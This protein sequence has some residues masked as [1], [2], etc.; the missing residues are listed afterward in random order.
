MSGSTFLL[1][2]MVEMGIEKRKKENEVCV[3]ILHII[4]CSETLMIPEEGAIEKTRKVDMETVIRKV[5][6]EMKEL[7]VKGVIE[8]AT[9]DL[10]EVV[11]VKEAMTA[12][13]I[14]C[15]SL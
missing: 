2:V 5:D 6:T 9:G 4:G 13:G 8:I 3:S 7:E 1:F 12:I 14:Q 11:I 15:S 10:T